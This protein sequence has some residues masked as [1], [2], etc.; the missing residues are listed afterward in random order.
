MHKLPDEM[1]ESSSLAL[2]LYGLL[3]VVL[4]V[5]VVFHFQK[6]EARL[7]LS[8]VSS[9]SSLLLLG[10]AS[11]CSLYLPQAMG[12]VFF[13]LSCYL[14]YRLFCS[15]GVLSPEGKAVL[16]TGCDS[17]FG[18][19]L[20]KRLHSLGFHVF[21][22]VLQEESD[23]A[24]ELKSVCSDRLTVIE[25]DVTNHAVIQDVRKE[26]AKQ[27]NNRG[28][29]ALVNNAGVIIHIGDAEIIPTDAY[30]RCME[31]NFLGTV[32][33]TKAFLPF[34]RRAKGR[35][36]NISS[37]SDETQKINNSNG[38]LL[39]RNIMNKERP[40]YIA[41][42]NPTEAFDHFS[43]WRNVTAYQAA[44]CDCHFVETHWLFFGNPSG[45]M[46]EEN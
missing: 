19:S 40:L 28:L 26:V 31:V 21:A 22:M 45:W 32:Q 14:V 4:G 8:V 25:M 17:G 42:I 13:A 2:G 6:S 20:A 15:D 38:L 33:V 1:E 36:I 16:I 44:Q 12:F 35:I 34:I 43:C 27:L 37:P 3:T 39:R 24:Q 30:K 10:A 7:N 11:L 5:A 41:F 29:F 18:H 9:V 46:P 23:G